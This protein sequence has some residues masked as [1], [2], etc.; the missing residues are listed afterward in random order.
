MK[1]PLVAI[2]RTSVAKGPGIGSLFGSRRKSLDTAKPLAWYDHPFFGKYPAIT[3]NQFG[4]GEVVYEGTVPSDA[5]QQALLARVLDH[6]QLSGP[7]RKLPASVRV[8]HGVNREGDAI[9]YYFNFSSSAQSIAYPYGSGAE[10]LSNH[11]IATGATLSLA[12]WDVAIVEQD[13]K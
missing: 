7:D 8:K 13:G 9:H 5:V 6:A 4:K 3:G 11:P 1:S 12:P 10:L 2:T